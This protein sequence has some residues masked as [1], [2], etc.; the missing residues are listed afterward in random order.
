MPAGNLQR[1]TA[2]G[3]MSAPKTRARGALMSRLLRVAVT[4][5]LG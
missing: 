4:V 5:G 2:A 3:S 1:A